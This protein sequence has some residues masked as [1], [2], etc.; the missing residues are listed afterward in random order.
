MLASAY[1][2]KNLKRILPNILTWS[3]EP[4]EGYQNAK[5]LYSEVIGQYGR[6]MGHVAKNVGGIYSTPK[7]V[8]EK[9]GMFQP[10]SFARQKE[11]MTFLNTQLFATPMWLINKELI[12][13][14]GVNPVDVFQ[15]VQKSTLARL[16]NANTISKLINDE[17][18][19]GNKAYT[20]FNLFSDLKSGIWSELSSHKTID[21]YRRNLQKAYVDN[22]IKLISAPAPSAGGSAFPGMRIADPTASD[23]SSVGRAHLS[24]LAKNIRAAI[25]GASGMSKFHL[26]DLLV[27]IN[28]ALNPKS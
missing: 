25:P 5:T 12:E 7:T 20:S 1:G 19:N 28:T 17:A 15:G 23:V 2:I 27:R 24:I 11:A 26:Q 14:T 13:R 10:V 6:Y 21:V 8:E 4:N 22:M 18:L 9:G 16:Q 3:K